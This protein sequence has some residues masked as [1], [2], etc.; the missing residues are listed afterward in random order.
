MVLMMSLGVS[1]VFFGFCGITLDGKIAL[2]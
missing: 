1:R 2:K